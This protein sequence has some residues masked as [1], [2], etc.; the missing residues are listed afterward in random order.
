MLVV[1]VIIILSHMAN[2]DRSK[3]LIAVS[4]KNS[5][6]NNTLS[7]LTD[8]AAP[9]ERNISSN[10]SEDFKAIRNSMSEQ[11]QLLRNIAQ[12]FARSSTQASFAALCIFL[13]GTALLLYGLRLTLK[14]TSKQA[15]VYLKVMMWALIIPVIAVIAIYQFQIVSGISFGFVK[16]TEPFFF[17]SVLLCIPVGIVIFL[18]IN[19]RRILHGHQDKQQ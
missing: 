2:F 14:A 19:E 12:G 5:P 6:I 18:L 11:V 16:I 3:E 7:A 13:L 9:Q 8:H 4:A 15:S 17:I 1:F 10:Q